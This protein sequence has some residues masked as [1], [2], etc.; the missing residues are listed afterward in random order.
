MGDEVTRGNR[1][2]A[3]SAFRRA[4][5][6]DREEAYE[7]DNPRCIAH[8]LRECDVCIADDVADEQNELPFGFIAVVEPERAHNQRPTPDDE[9]AD[10]ELGEP[11]HL[12]TVAQQLLDELGPQVDDEPVTDTDVVDAICAI[13]SGVE[14]N[15]ETLAAVAVVIGWV[16]E[17]RTDE[18]GLTWWGE[19]R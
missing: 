11:F 5:E 9:Y 10:A 3:D 8:G 17:S 19:E 14:W 16:R 4:I 13:I 7:A 12:G 2:N 1:F 18:E 6:R 15:A